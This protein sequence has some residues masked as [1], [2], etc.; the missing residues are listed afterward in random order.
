V[1]LLGSALIVCSDGPRA[2]GLG[3]TLAG[4]GIALALAAAGAWPAALPLA[5][6]GAL[7]G[8]LLQRGEPRWRVLPPGSTPRVIM[9]VVAAGVAAWFALS[10]LPG[11]GQR[12]VRAATVLVLVLPGSRLV[13]AS[14]QRAVLGAGSAVALAAG[15]AGSFTISGP[16]VAL[17]AGSLAIAMCF[18]GAVSRVEV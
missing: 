14:E 13:S 4:A 6:S 18:L 3:L 2:I 5:I 9:S 15:A 1:A 10:A 11:P 16:A 17:G 7:S 12:W 8:V